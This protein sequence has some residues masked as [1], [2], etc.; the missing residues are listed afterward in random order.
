MGAVATVTAYWLGYTSGYSE[1][2][3]Q[4]FKEGKRAGA[5]EGSI[6]GYAVGFDRG[7]RTQAAAPADDAAS[8]SQSS[9]SWGVVG[10]LAAIVLIFVV[11]SQVR[12]NQLPSATGSALETKPA[13]SRPLP[14]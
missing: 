13:A 14:N 3:D 9:V 12:K 1:G 8:T 7:K 6:K 10:F 11:A 5:R 2:R 4:G